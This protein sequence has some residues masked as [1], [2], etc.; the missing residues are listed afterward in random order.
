MN[1]LSKS[2]NGDYWNKS[3]TKA[4]QGIMAL[5]IIFHHM[6]QKTCAP[7]LP[8]EYIVHGLDPFLNLGFLFV[9][10][11]FFCSGYGLYK[12]V[13]SNPEYL[14]G[15]IG[16]HFRPIIFLYILS[17]VC[18]YMIGQTLNNYTWFIYA[19][20]YLYLAFYISFKYFKKERNSII[21]LTCFIVL[22]I[23]VCEIF[24]LG[25][26]VYNTVGV[27]LV[28]LFVA[29]Y[30]DKTVGFIRNKY[31]LCLIGSIA[32]LIVTFICALYSNGMINTMETKPLYHLVRI[33]TLILQLIC[34]T[35][36]SMIFFILNQKIRFNCKPLEFIGGL[37]LEIYLFHVLYV[38]MFGYCFV[39]TQNKAVCYIRSIIPYTLTVVALS[40]I[41][42]YALMLARKG[43]RLL[44]QKYTPLFLSL[45]KDIKKIVLFVL[46]GIAAVSVLLTII[47]KTGE[48]DRKAQVEEYKEKNTSYVMVNDKYISY[49]SAG[50]GDK[51]ILVF[52][53]EYDPCPSLSQKK[54]ADD[55]SADFRVIIVD[56]PGCGFSDAPTTDRSVE[57]I[58]EELHE[59]AKSLKLEN[60][61]LLSETIS[62]AYSLYYVN[63]YP[64]EVSAVIAIDGEYANYE[65]AYFEVQNMSIYE[66]NRHV[67]IDSA[68][69]YL[70]A[71]II[72]H[73]G[74]KTIV[75]PLYQ[76]SFARN[77]GIKNDDV[78]YETYFRNMNN[79]VTTNERFYMVDNCLKTEGM[80][81]PKE[82][83]VIDL[84]SDYKS[85]WYSN[86]GID[87]S[88]HLNSLCENNEDHYIGKILDAQYCVVINPSS[89]VKLVKENLK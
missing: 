81:Y 26:W 44:Y 50:E 64:G 21:V 63:K 52:K 84:I 89:I 70:S 61:V 42:A 22:Y 88:E 25:P 73:C 45:G 85:L 14:K 5:G 47:N 15:F 43:L 11:F 54:M 13:K 62:S 37:S 78:S 76:A 66:Y 30:A 4:I 68:L 40:L 41:T 75:W 28:G 53:G 18:F 48:E 8:K 74:F 58:C 71:R 55:F 24:V 35:S 3:Q 10:I 9:G 23:A 72:E 36:F 7:W 65:R 6:A 31:E 69:K 60:Y 82:I 83:Q 56:L 39:T 38:E 19:I 57:N 1:N 29:K 20:L 32:I 51:T 79:K 59:V 16:K 33:V 67:K 34:A 87:I 2:W 17:N 12:S 46:I 27:F 49:Y 86:L 77:V 80:K